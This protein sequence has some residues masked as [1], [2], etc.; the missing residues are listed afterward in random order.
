M[1]TRIKQNVIRQNIHN[2][3]MRWRSKEIANLI[4]KG[5][6]PLKV[7][8]WTHG[9]GYHFSHIDVLRY[10]ASIKQPMHVLFYPMQEGKP[11]FV[12]R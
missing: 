5:L 12:Y 4:R 8:I 6:N 10:Y 2:R 9:G 1:T 11:V 3:T 7:H